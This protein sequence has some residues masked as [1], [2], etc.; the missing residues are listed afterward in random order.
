MKLVITLVDDDGEVK[1]IAEVV[2]QDAAQARREYFQI[3][4][5]LMDD[6]H[7]RIHFNSDAEK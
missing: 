1:E 2:Y 7:K 5:R 4:N 3:A 6:K